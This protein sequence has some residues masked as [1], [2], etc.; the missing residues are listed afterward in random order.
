MLR[1]ITG[2]PGS[3]KSYYAMQYLMKYC[4]YDKH[5]NTFHLQTDT[6][7]I[8]NIE[9]IKVNYIH[10]EEL[11]NNNLLNYDRFKDW[12]DKKG[13]KK[14][15]I[16][17][18]EC[19]RYLANLKDNEQYYFFEYHRHLGIDLLLICQVAAALPKRLVELCEFV[20]NAKPRSIKMAGFQYDFL[21]SVSRNKLYTSTIKPSKGVFSL[22]QSYV[23]DESVKPKSVART[24]F[25]VGLCTVVFMLTFATYY[26]K[27]GFAFIKRDSASTNSKK[28]VATKVVNDKRL[29]PEQMPK[30]AE[31]E[32]KDNSQKVENN[33]TEIKQ[34]ST[35]QKVSDE[36]K[37]K[38]IAFNDKELKYEDIRIGDIGNIK[39]KMKYNGK[40][41]LYY[42]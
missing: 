29:N 40:V 38:F 39:G 28:V 13:Y 6:L 36:K 27:N 12:I 16:I 26:L 25:I 42:E 14:V 34:V 19:Q 22:Y 5:L 32:Q 41:Y 4:N 30:K 24:K 20:I 11:F 15:V 9:G 18:D 33:N 17:I 37:G 3:G 1:L 21:D 2:N 35:E 10:I 23:A 7:L 8:T 31:I